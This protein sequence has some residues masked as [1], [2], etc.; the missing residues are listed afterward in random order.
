MSTFDFHSSV[1]FSHPWFNLKYKKEY[2][3]VSDAQ[4]FY[5]FLESKTSVTANRL[6]DFSAY[7]LCGSLAYAYSFVF[8]HY[9][10]AGWNAV[11]EV[12]DEIGFE[13]ERSRVKLEVGIRAIKSVSNQPD[14]SFFDYYE[15]L[16]LDK[17]KSKEVKIVLQCYKIMKMLE[18]L[19]NTEPKLFFSKVDEAIL[20]F[21]NKCLEA[22]DI[23]EFDMSPYLPENM[24]KFK[25]ELPKK[26]KEEFKSEIKREIEE[27]REKYPEN[28]DEQTVLSALSYTINWDFFL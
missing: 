12:L 15:E 3:C 18:P 28:T 8:C 13:Y 25:T 1:R 21:R 2:K 4:A 24:P 9:G 17:P 6:I 11:W 23:I 7:V 14:D 10:E 22:N 5:T 20:D 27:W 26:V 16:V 19:K